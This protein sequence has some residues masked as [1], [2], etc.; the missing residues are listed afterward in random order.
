LTDQ[1]A[2]MY[3][4]FDS[5][6]TRTILVCG[7]IA[8][9]NIMVFRDHFKNHILPDKVDVLNVSFQIS[10]MRREFGGCAGNIAYGLVLLGDVPLPVATVGNDFSSYA[11]WMDNHGIIR[12]YLRGIDNTLTA[13]AFIITDLD[14][15]QITTFYPG[16]M[17]FSHENPISMKLEDAVLGIVSPDSLEGMKQH[18]TSL[19]E[20]GIPFLFDPGQAMTMFY[21]DDL[22]N[23]LEKASWVAVNDYEWEML[24]KRTGF[25][26]RKVLEWV[27]ALIVTHGAKG[28]V[29][30]VQKNS[31]EIPA[32]PIRQTVDPTGCGDA[33][34]AGLLHGLLNNMDWETSGRIATLMGAINAQYVG[35]QNYYFSSD[36]I[37]DRFKAA[38]GYY[39]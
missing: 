20:R 38:F 6:D 31:I 3:S 23:F 37:R 36:E 25:S 15:N 5:K 7:S 27:Q 29:I 8:Y 16:A 26:V 4:S 34:R 17:A 14:N 1:F 2:S 12:H 24:Q 19:S 30:Y 11:D 39:Y 28:S 35:T 10:E 13:Q 32:L 18:A 22:N 9:D 33:Y 21:K